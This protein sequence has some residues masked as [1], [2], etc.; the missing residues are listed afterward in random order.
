MGNRSHFRFD[1]DNKTTLYIFSTVTREIGQIKTHTNTHTYIYIYIW[2]YWPCRI[3]R[4]WPWFQLTVVSIWRNNIKCRCI[5]LFP[6]KKIA[7]KGLSLYLD[8]ASDLRVKT[9][10]PWYFT[11]KNNPI[12]SRKYISEFLDTQCI[13][14]FALNEY[15]RATC[16]SIGLYHSLKSTL[17]VIK[18]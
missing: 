9:V 2:W 3:G 11:T 12:N 8:P 10:Q 17:T 18:N 5:F 7:R 14:S 4:P 16:N 1:D 13:L 15:R 6:L